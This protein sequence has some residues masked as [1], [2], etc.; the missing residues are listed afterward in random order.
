MKE[1][2]LYVHIPFCVQKCAYCDFLSFPEEGAL[3][4]AYVQRL[5]E[6]IETLSPAY[7]AYQVATVIFGGG[8]PTVLEGYAL[9]RIMT[10]IFKSFKVSATAEISMECNPGTL[11]KAKAAAL[12]AMGVNRLSLGLQSAKDAELKALGRIHTWQQFLESFDAARKAGFS[13]INVDLMSALP[14]QTVA[15][16]EGTL[17]KVLA[18]RPEHIS[19]YSLIIEENTPFFHRYGE[20]LRRREAGEQPLLLPSEEEE[21]QM[22][23][24]TKSLLEKRGYAQYEISNYARP[25]F[26][27]WHN[28][29]YWIGTD[30]LGLGLGASSLIDN[31]RFVNTADLQQYLNEPF[32]RQEETP[33]SRQEAMEEF[34]F[35]GL[36]LTEGVSRKDFENRFGVAVE[37]VYGT[38]LQE[39]EA[40]GLLAC[41]EGKIRLTQRG[42]DVSNR[43]FAALLL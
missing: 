19:A 30:Y 21:R 41:A 25:G 27:C 15:S 35:L 43:V 29:G 20:D 1:L 14:G 26:A 7:A 22:Y 32:A 24:L 23:A 10:A 3:R 39:L 16:W 37:A 31:V 13:N 2:L 5:I 18:L 38:R 40:A 17:K 42:V 11:T 33:R 28:T 36:R 34:F 8:T 6:E 12:H 9:E 4:H